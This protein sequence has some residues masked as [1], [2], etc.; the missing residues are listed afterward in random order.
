L[1]APNDAQPTY[2]DVSPDGAIAAQLNGSAASPICF[3]EL[4]YAPS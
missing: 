3:D 2:L 4:A 1:C